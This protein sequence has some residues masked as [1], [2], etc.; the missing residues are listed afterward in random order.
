MHH[1]IIIKHAFELSVS[2]ETEVGRHRIE[3][4]ECEYQKE[5]YHVATTFSKIGTERPCLDEETYGADVANPVV[6]AEHHVDDQVTEMHLTRG[7]EEDQY[8]HQ[9]L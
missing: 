7:A 5:C 8:K 3:D 6:H 9:V 2:F 4:G 1:S